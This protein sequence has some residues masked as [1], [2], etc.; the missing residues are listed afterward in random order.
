MKLLLIDDDQDLVDVLGYALR[1]E[2]YTVIAAADGEQGLQRWQ[3]EHPDLILL[4]VTLP[5]VNGFEVCRQIRHES[6]VPIIMLT[7][8]GAED[9]VLRGFRLGA[10][11]YVVKPFSS[12]QL[13]SRVAAVLRRAAADS[14]QQP[15]RQVLV[16]DLSLDLE[17]YQVTR[18]DRVVQLTL[19]EFRILYLLA[20]NANRVV[21]Y[22]RLVEYG[23]GYDDIYTGLESSLLKSHVSHIRQKLQ[24]RHRH[25]PDIAVLTGVGYKLWVP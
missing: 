14:F 20:L 22:S 9:H 3:S 11:D 15:S 8:Q 13:A 21:P 19:L 2:G 12:K 24:F 25:P 1:R 7:G 4:D 18:G 10:D 23:W 17:T 16:G 5:K 6:S